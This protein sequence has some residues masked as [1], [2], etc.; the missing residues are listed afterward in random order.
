MDA[1]N[2]FERKTI[3]KNCSNSKDIQFI[4]PNKGCNFYKQTF[5][6]S[7]KISRILKVFSLTKMCFLTVFLFERFIRKDISVLD[8][9]WVAVFAQKRQSLFNNQSWYDLKSKISTNT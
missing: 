5:E 9:S 2:C 7:L 4:V 6:S 3:G 8:K 1:L